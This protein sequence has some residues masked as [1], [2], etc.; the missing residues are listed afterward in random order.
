MGRRALGLLLAVASTGC[1][2]DTPTVACAAYAAA[3]L[4]VSVVNASTG[5][6]VCDATV[7][8]RDGTH[9]ERLVAVGCT[10]TGAYERP[11]TYV[12]EASRPGFVPKRVDSVRVVMGRGECPHVEQAHVTVSMTPVGELSTSRRPRVGSR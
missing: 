1:G 10:F 3:G 2:T 9:S 12:I 11:G 7:T 6:A 8:A 4:G 5:A